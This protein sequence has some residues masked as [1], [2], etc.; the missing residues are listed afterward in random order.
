MELGLCKSGLGQG[1]AKVLHDEKMIV[2]PGV[3]NGHKKEGRKACGGN[4][5]YLLIY[6]LFSAKLVQKISLFAIAELSPRKQR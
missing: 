6:Y 5:R 1:C 2:G 4:L 3:T